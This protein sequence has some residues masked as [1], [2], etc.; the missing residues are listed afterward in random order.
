[1]KYNNETYWKELHGSFNGSLKAVG[2][3]TLSESFNRAKYLSET[4]SFLQALEL[5]PLTSRSPVHVLEIGIGIGFWTSILI[6]RLSKVDFHVTGL[7][8]SKDALAVVRARFPDVDL[9]QADLRSVNP[10]QFLHRFDLVTAMMVLL[11]LT[12]P[13]EFDNALR[14]AARSVQRG[15]TLLLYEP[16]ITE[17]YSP[18]LV[19]K[20]TEGN[21]LARRLDA[22][23]EPLA[24]ER[25]QRVAILPGASWVLN[26]PIEAGN[27]L[28]FHSRQA[29]WQG[30][31][32]IAFRFDW[33]SKLITP[34]MCRIDAALRAGTGAG[35]GKFLIYRRLEA[36]F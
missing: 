32:R 4:E 1:M 15:G 2:W 23:D 36:P 8:I 28:N 19:G 17:T 34:L 33:P 31:S 21:S 5:C 7:D 16:A 22:F 6:E 24:Q 30:L 27:E 10:N 14:F 35:S 20:M 13:A 12:V 9:E 25:L 29:I 3:P 11:H 26:S 18:W